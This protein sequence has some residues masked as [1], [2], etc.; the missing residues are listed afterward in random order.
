MLINQVSKMNHFLFSSAHKIMWILKKKTVNKRL[1]ISHSIKIIKDEN[2]SLIRN[3]KLW[4][5]I[6]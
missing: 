4:K 3:K 1:K 5:E 6:K 2:H